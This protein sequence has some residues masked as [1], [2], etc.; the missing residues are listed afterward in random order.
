[1]KGLFKSIYGITEEGVY[2][3]LYSRDGSSPST[4]R[5][6]IRLGQVE[7]DDEDDEEED[8]SVITAP[9]APFAP[10]APDAAPS[11]EEKPFFSQEF[12]GF[13]NWLIGVFLLG[14][15]YAYRRRKKAI[16]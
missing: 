16:S 3:D 9:E 13:P 7:E 15:A 2:N 6:D 4:K 8:I 12:L 11:T 5:M 10:P 1:M 14:F